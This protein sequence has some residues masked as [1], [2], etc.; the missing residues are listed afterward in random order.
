MKF[1]MR[2]PSLT[3]SIKARTTGKLKR[4]VKSSINPFYGKKEM[5]LITNPRKAVY[6]K[7][8]KKTTFSF[9]DLFK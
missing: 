7:V 8:Y 9:L 2:K 3:K 1:G 6:N 4:K 5:G